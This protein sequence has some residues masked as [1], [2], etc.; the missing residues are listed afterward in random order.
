[1]LQGCVPCSSCVFIFS[2]VTVATDIR[3][4][5]V[6]ESLDLTLVDSDT[7]EGLGGTSGFRCLTPDLGSDP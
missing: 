1:M 5:Y 4:D 2:L 3:S 7:K 6:Q